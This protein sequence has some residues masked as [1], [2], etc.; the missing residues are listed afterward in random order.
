MNYFGTDGIRGIV[1]VDLY[2]ATIIKLGNALKKLNYDS[3]YIG[4]DTRKTAKIIK[5]LLVKGI[6]NNIKIYDIGVASTPEIMYISGKYN[7][8]GIAIT[9]SHNPAK[10]NGIKLIINGCKPKKKDLDLIS[11]YL[12]SNSIRLYNNFSIKIDLHQDYI[13][14]LSK[15]LVKSNMKAV[16]DSANGALYNISRLVLDNVFENTIHI[17]CNPNG[18][19]INDKCGALYLES[20]INTVYENKYDIG[21]AFDGDGDRIIVIDKNGNVIDGDLI[22]YILAN[23]MNLNKIALTKMA[24]LGIINEYKKKGIKV[25]I[26]DVGDTNLLE[27]MEEKEILLG[28]EASGHIIPR[29]YTH[30]GDGLFNL[31]LLINAVNNGLNIEKLYDSIEKYYTKTI[32]I[33]L[34]EGYHPNILDDIIYKYENLYKDDFKLIF[35]KS[36]TENLIRLTICMKKEE[37]A[38]K[39]LDECMN[40]IKKIA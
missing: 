11:S 15:F 5:T 25:Y 8:L 29:M 1:G 28:S 40:E 37:D 3:V 38:L 2:Y 32:N 31:L 22:A 23:H 34:F 14:Y 16:I 35:R 39:V 36:G 4:Y 7:A 27:L 13:S 21:I 19:N 20:L 9:A 10:Y 6:P 30:I 12:S 18:T 26:S 17:G 24:D 33:D